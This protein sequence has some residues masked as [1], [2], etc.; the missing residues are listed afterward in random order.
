MSTIDPAVRQAGARSAVRGWL[1][2]LAVTLGIFALMT[3]ELLPVGLLTPVG[4]ALDVSEGT[5]GLMVTVPGLVAA[6]SAPLVTVA[7]GR[8][9]RRLILAVLV[10]AVGAAGSVFTS[11][12]NLSIALGALAGGLAVDA[13]GADSVLWIGVVLILPAALLVRRAGATGAPQAIPRVL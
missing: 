12:F 6:V 5:A 1:A 10:G 4:A 8:L 2:V 11:M 13:A 7:T 9:D 3:S